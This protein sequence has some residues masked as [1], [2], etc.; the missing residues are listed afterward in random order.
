MIGRLLQNA[1]STFSQQPAGTRP[2]QQPP[3]PPPPPQ[4]Q[5]HHQ[6]Q[7][8]LQQHQQGSPLE[9]V[10]EETHTRGLLYPDIQTLR[11]SLHDLA[12]GGAARATTA[13][14]AVNYDDRGGI[15]VSW[16]AD[17]RI[18]VAQDA[19]SLQPQ[20]QILYDSRSVR[21]G[22]PTLPLGAT[23]TASAPRPHPRFNKSTT[24][25]TTAPTATTSRHRHSP[26]GSFFST[27]SPTSPRS[28]ADKS[29]FTAAD[30]RPRG[31]A[32]RD[33]G[34]IDAET[35]LGRLTREAKEDTDALLGCMFGAPGFRLEPGTKLHI[36]PRKFADGEPYSSKE[37]TNAGVP[38][39]ISS[40]GQGGFHRRPTPL[41]RSTSAA[42]VTVRVPQSTN[43]Y[44]DSKLGPAR[45]SIMFTRLFTV[46]IADSTANETGVGLAA[47]AES[48]GSPTPRGTAE[49]L[50]TRQ[51]KQK[52]T[53][54][55]AIAVI[56]QLPH[57]NPNRQ[58]SNNS[59]KGISPSSSSLT[60]STPATSWRGEQS[61]FASFME[62]R[63]HGS[64]DT[65]L[66]THIQQVLQ[67]WNILNRALEMVEYFAKGQL[68]Q[69]LEQTPS[70]P[71]LSLDPSPRSGTTTTK[72]KKPTS[73]S[74]QTVYVPPGCLQN[75]VAA[76]KVIEAAG[77]R[78][79]GALKTRRV[80]VGQGRWG[81]WREEARWV[82]RWAGGK[83]QNFF[84]FNCLTAFL[85]THTEWLEMLA[86]RWYRRRYAAQKRSR[87]NKLGLAHR[88]VIVS[89]EKMAARRLI[90]LLAS[91]LP[92]QLN[93]H[94]ESSQAR[95][96]HP[97]LYSDSPP[98]FA[99]NNRE[100]GL[101]RVNTQKSSLGRR[102]GTEVSR[103]LRSVSFSLD[104]DA[105]E[106]A[107][108]DDP[109]T[110]RAR[111]QSDT[112]S[113]R[114]T[115]AVVTPGDSVS[116]K[117]S[118]STVTAD[119]VQAVPHFSN[120]S[121]DEPTS[122]IVERVR[123][124][125]GGSLASSALSHTLKRSESTA[126]DSASVSTGRWGSLV[127]GFWS[128]RR[129]SSTDD[130][131]LY[132][133]SQES[134]QKAGFS[135]REHRRSATALHSM[136]EEA[137]GLPLRNSPSQP[138]L[139]SGSPRR[140]LLQLEECLKSRHAGVPGLSEYGGASA[141][142]IPQPPRKPDH[143]P[144]KLSYNE[145]EGYLDIDLDREH[146]SNLSLASSF[147]SIRHPLSI[148]MTLPQ[149]PQDHI[150][151][152]G[153]IAADPAGT[154]PHSEPALNVAGWLKVY[155]PDFA[156][157]AVRA[158]EE[159]R[160]DIEASMQAEAALEQS[161]E[162]ESGSA[163]VFSTD[164]TEASVTL[165]ADTSRFTLSRL[166][167]LRRR[168]VHSDGP[169][170]SDKLDTHGPQSPSSTTPQYETKFV[171]EPIMDLDPTLTAALDHILGASSSSSLSRSSSTRG[172]SSRAVSPS[173][174]PPGSEARAV[175]AS[176]AGQG[177]TRQRRTL[178]AEEIVAPVSA[179]AE[180]ISTPH[181]D[182]RRTVLGALEDVAT[183]IAA[184][185]TLD[186]HQSRGSAVEP[187]HERGSSSETAGIGHTEKL[188]ASALPID[189]LSRARR[190]Q[191]HGGSRYSDRGH[192]AAADSSVKSVSAAASE[193][194]LREGVRRW[195]RAVE[196][197]C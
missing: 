152:Y 75:E 142:S 64:F 85:G 5:H 52:R 45:P 178:C 30:G 22:S 139:L 149:D 119:A 148:S 150:S 6:Y 21:L 118:M 41:V 82:S 189:V 99:S 34:N 163:N 184:E 106:D 50:A 56:L 18:I 96:M 145:D 155:Q 104:I 57:E 110:S 26:S 197:E 168:I 129:D 135:H 3:P 172:P 80:V 138:S 167:L 12:L 101:Q 182:C 65:M 191:P 58:R 42:D 177:T 196:M 186:S 111:R 94:Q 24:N 103:H 4:Q 87:G 193:S 47:H 117:A 11:A 10:T 29:K 121:S 153:S 15:D 13:R 7:Q 81:A 159:L 183:S 98:R 92:A 93:Y 102:S 70:V 166:I 17:V 35:A 28:P 131:E 27:R 20:P 69:L 89:P 169:S 179:W 90:F 77:L 59:P 126:A 76:K 36:V 173:S 175:P 33:Y 1:A 165:V 114:N 95:E 151:P 32:P 105:E 73:Q 66:N 140:Q 78:I 116:R 112:H 19:H 60:D 39:P 181:A 49:F 120:L 123:L 144:L 9:S 86:P 79:V 107:V 62:I 127:S 154:Q 125:S 161:R 115:T 192:V 25:P 71:L 187:D 97:L 134:P 180:N 130:S 147:T 8:Q 44:S 37:A 133:S 23:D 63:S 160:A 48:Q 136:V 171:S 67:H 188:S 176:Q 174:A 100:S 109:S 158:Y 137:D 170:H 194:T 113:L 146:S 91:F 195:M 132:V 38:R 55:Y 43:E 74:Q 122:P 16:P 83:E 14:D 128:N 108:I 185:R 143:L 61:A 164:W 190:T 157:Q 72:L 84:L 54:M 68:R 124:G 162:H 46:P 156:L 40:G 88:T 51:M 141:R 53:P 31:F 2:Q